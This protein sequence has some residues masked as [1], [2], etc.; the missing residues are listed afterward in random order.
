MEAV[1]SAPKA[2]KY[3]SLNSRCLLDIFTAY[4]IMQR[5]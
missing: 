2:L 5:E 1:K 3:A 4:F